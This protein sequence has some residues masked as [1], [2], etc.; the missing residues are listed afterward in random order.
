MCRAILDEYSAECLNVPTTPAEWEQVAEGY[1]NKWNF[2]HVLGSLDGKHVACQCPPGSGSQYYNY[3]KFYSIVL[4]AM[5]D[6]DYKFIW[7]DLGGKGSASDA[8]IWNDS[9]LKEAVENGTMPLPQPR[10]LPHDNQD[11]SYFFIGEYKFN[12]LDFLFMF[13]YVQNSFSQ[14]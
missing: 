2:P 11:T 7:A 3:K 14:H 1:L 4:L 8:Q 9:D 6:A 13:Q 10:P 12:T 5:V